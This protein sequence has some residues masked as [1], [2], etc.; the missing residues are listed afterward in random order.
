MLPAPRPGPSLSSKVLFEDDKDFPF[1][2]PRVP[3]WTA[4][5]AV[6][7]LEPARFGVGFDRFHPSTTT[8]LTFVLL[9]VS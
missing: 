3:A 9:F 8:E 4:G 1:S 5:G 6:V 2:Q 7:S